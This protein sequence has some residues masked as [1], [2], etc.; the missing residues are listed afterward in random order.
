MGS[1]RG[2]LTYGTASRVV[3]CYRAGPGRRS[4]GRPKDHLV[5]LVSAAGRRNGPALRVVEAALTGLSVLV[6]IVAFATMVRRQFSHSDGYLKRQKRKE[7]CLSA[8]LL[9]LRL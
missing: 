6:G 7:A 9:D 2:R 4:S 1:L 5:V 3:V 8:K